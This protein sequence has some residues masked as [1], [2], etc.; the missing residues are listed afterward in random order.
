[1]GRVNLLF[2]DALTLYTSWEQP[3]VIISD[4]PYGVNGYDGDLS[5]ADELNEWYAPHIKSWSSYSSALTTLWFWNTEIGWAEV[6]PV[7]KANGWIY[8]S[9]NVWDKGIGHVAGNSNTKTLRRFPVVTEVCAHYIRKPEFVL[10]DQKGV[11]AKDW[12]RAEWKR[13]RLPFSK[14]N[15]VCGVKNAAS[16]KYL[17]GD[18]LWYFPPPEVFEK[19]VAYANKYGNEKGRPYFSID[20]VNVLSGSQWEQLRGKFYCE[21]GVTNVWQC[22]AVRGKER[23]KID[24]KALHPNQKPMSLMNRIIISSSDEGDVIWEPFGGLCSASIVAAKLGRKA[25]VAEANLSTYQY[26][27]SRLRNEGVLD[28]S[29]EI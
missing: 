9:C 26:A 25:F 14:S 13:T 2:G 16:R 24:N 22:P 10:G 5:K 7:L 8:R 20:G 1:M 11:S 3:V 17:T 23:I 21:A 4:G 15:E 29:H 18:H 27:C 12:L 19:L 6:H 28:Q